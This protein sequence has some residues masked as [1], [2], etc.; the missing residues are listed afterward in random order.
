MLTSN[1]NRRYTIIYDF[2]CMSDFAIPDFQQDITSLNLHI[3]YPSILPLHI[4]YQLLKN[5]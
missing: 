2:L 5:P 4:M 3:A 1:R